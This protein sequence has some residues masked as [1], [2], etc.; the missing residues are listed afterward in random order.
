M[1]TLDNM[2]NIEALFMLNHIITQFGVPQDVVIDRG[3]HFRNFTMYQ[4][5]KKLGLH[6]E[7]STPY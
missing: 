4:L 5:T 7:K 3:S 2:G 1:P 6:H